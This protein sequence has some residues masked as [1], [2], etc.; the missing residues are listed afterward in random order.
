MRKYNKSRMKS[1][2]LGVIIVV[3]SLSV[4][5]YLM[6]N[7]GDDINDK[8][9][10][11]QTKTEQPKVDQLKA[12]NDKIYAELEAVK[13]Q[14]YLILVNK[15]NPVLPDYVPSDLEPIKYYAE[16]RTPIARFMRKE[17]AD[18]FHKMVEAAKEAGYEIL[19][20]TA[21]RDYNFQKTLNDN[22]IANYGEAAA[23]RFSAKPGES[24]HQT[25]LAV[26]I[27]AKSVNYTLTEDFGE[28]PEGI[29][30]SENCKTYGFILRYT[31]ESE[32]IT[33]YNFE[34]WHFRYT[35]T[36]AANI[37]YDKNLTL[38]EFLSKLK[39]KTLL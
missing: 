34:P 20:T 30:L 17:V 6:L 10:K 31:K 8:D 29:W 2:L 32:E 24:E 5:G 22:Y 19:M 35:G 36:T 37:I 39:D 1:S 15:N 11:G 16:D 23:S 33:G 13:D 12:E 27:T 3:A 4:G 28:T 25:G 9:S 14:G 38:E 21:Y 26:D 7:Q 18:N